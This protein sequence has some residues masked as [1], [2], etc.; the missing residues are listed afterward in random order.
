M[1][2]LGDFRRFAPGAGVPGVV[3]TGTEA[4]AVADDADRAKTEVMIVGEPV[5]EPDGGQ[6]V[7][8]DEHGN[9]PI[10]QLAQKVASPTAGD[11]Q[12]D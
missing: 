5:I 3:G 6:I 1:P 2:L 4:F 9:S 7:A 11:R 12:C 10:R 8:T